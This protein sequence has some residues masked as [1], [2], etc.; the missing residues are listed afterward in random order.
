MTTRSPERIEFLTDVLTTAVEGGI[1]YWSE[2]RK[3]LHEAPHAHAVIVDYEHGEKYHVDI[4]TIAEGLSLVSK[5]SVGGL[6][7]RYRKAIVHADRLNT[8]SPD[9]GGHPDIDSEIAD[10]V[11]QISLFGEVVYG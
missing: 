7:E 2:L 4:D 11:V 5:A 3:Y 8:C 6:P 9:Y 1:G 10:M